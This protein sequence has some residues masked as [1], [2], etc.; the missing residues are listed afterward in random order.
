MKHYIICMIVALLGLTSCQDFL[1]E[2]PKGTIIPKTVN[3]FGMMLDNYDY[4]NC[5][6]VFLVGSQ[7][8]YVGRFYL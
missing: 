6:E 3:D 7:W 5:I 1:D 2:T 4:D 8:I